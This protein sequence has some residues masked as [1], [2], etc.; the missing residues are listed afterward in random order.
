MLDVRKLLMLR[1]IAAEGSIAAAARA[2][3]YTRSAV[4]QQLTALESEAGI[5]LVDRVGNR[6]T[7]TSAGRALVEHTERI[8]VELRAAE[9][10]LGSDTLAVSGLLRVGVPFHEGP[11]IMSRALTDVRHRFPE[12]QIRLVATTDEAGADEVRRDQL[13]MVIVSR[14]G[15]PHPRTTPGLRE[16]VLGHDPLL[17]CVPGAHRL[18]GARNCTMAQLREEAWIVCLDSALGQLTMSLCTTAGFE[19]VL[20]ATV[21]DIGTAI[22]LVGIGWGITIAPELTPAGSELPVA[23]IP[24]EGVDTMRHSV[25]IVRDGEQTSPRIAAAIAA[26]RSVSAEHGTSDGV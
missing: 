6:V 2:L 22:G 4:S 25:L 26:V 5:A 8:L 20:A 11:R 15:A 24:I 9:A 10:M 23:R 21:N 1:S 7:L 12:M 17:L 14:L 19:P 13:D 16:W 18:A 3:N